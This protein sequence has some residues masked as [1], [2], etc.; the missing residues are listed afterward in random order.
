MLLPYDLKEWLP[1]NHIVHFTI[2]AAEMVP[3][4]Q[5][6]VN[7]RGSGD[8]VG[9]EIE[10]LTEL[11]A[12]MRVAQEGIEKRARE[13][14]ER[15]HKEYEDKVRDRNERNGSSK[16]RF[17]KKPKEE[18]V[19]TEQ[20]NLTDADSRIMR[21]NKRSEYFQGYNAQAVVDA[22][23][24]MLVVGCRV[25][26]NA[27]DADELA[28]DIAAIP[29]VLGK[30]TTALADKGYA[31]EKPVGAVQEQEIE[32]LVSVTKETD[33]SPRRHDFRP[34]K[35]PL[36]PAPEKPNQLQ[37]V[38]LMDVMGTDEAKK[39]YRL[40]KQSV[41]PV[42]GIVKQILGFRQFLLRGLEKVELEWE[43]V[44]CAYNLKRLA[45]LCS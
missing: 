45:V 14:A 20:A 23:G 44:L 41:E 27:S 15:E 9:A 7:E 3:V 38:K 4:E 28:R 37:W 31:S 43:L 11:K 13:R 8:E 24:T 39:P 12:K 32:V 40:R 30:P 5:F 21:K 2:A 34:K 16:G 18:P 22:D 36:P 10:R 25:T 6:V 17:I 42:F 26:N 35:D 33:H 1:A 19:D 29:T